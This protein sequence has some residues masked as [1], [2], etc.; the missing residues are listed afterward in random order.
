MSELSEKELLMLSNFAYFSCSMDSGTI[1]ENISK[2][3]DENGQF[4][5]EKLNMQGAIS[6][7]ISEDEAISLLSEMENNDKLS[8]LQLRRYTNDGGIRGL[9][10]TDENDNA[11]LVFRGTGGTYKAWNDNVQGEYEADTKLQKLAKDFVKYE[12]GEFK[13]ITVTGHSKG[14]NLAQYVTVTCGDQ[15]DRCVSYDGQ[16]FGRK[17]LNEYKNEILTA[18][19]KITSISA[20]NDFVNI[21]L[22]SIAGSTVYVKNNGSGV[23][24]HSSYTLLSSSV[25]DSNGNFDRNL[26]A[27]EQ[28]FLIR[29]V[30]KALDTTVSVFDLLPEDGNEKTSNVL[31]AIVASVMSSDKGE[32]Y[33]EKKLKASVNAMK[34]YTNSMLGLMGTASVCPEV[35]YMYSQVT[36]DKL[37][38]V[39]NE[40][41]SQRNKLLPIPE[42]IE[43]ILVSLDYSIA[44]RTITEMSLKRIISKTDRIIAMMNKYMETLLLIIKGYE[45]MESDMIQAIKND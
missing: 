35:K 17:F 10:Y 38:D 34:D 6:S 8:T 3:K 25:Y 39:Y 7:N 13:D 16:G 30:K 43:D 19:E 22:A 41:D 32:E 28:S 24:A 37:N 2:L 26:D 44:G 36:V 1:G 18:K 21:L 4:D 12:C 40:F 29:N 9:L 20:Y 27:R 14:G 31:A 42:M 15:I 23:D 5:I 11:T 45:K 33:E